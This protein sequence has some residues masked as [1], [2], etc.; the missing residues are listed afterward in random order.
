MRS[1]AERAA[2][3]TATANLK[4]DRRPP[5]HMKPDGPMRRNDCGSAKKLTAE[6]EWKRRDEVDEKKTAAADLSNDHDD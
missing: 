5:R 3:D 6:G 1:A 2:S 4:K